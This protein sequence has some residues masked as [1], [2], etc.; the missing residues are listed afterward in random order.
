MT[1][2]PDD[3]PPIVT[4]KM[5]AAAAPEAHRA[6]TVGEVRAVLQSE[7]DGALTELAETARK[8]LAGVPH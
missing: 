7:I 2:N 1:K 6:K 3:L 8:H 4:G 5:L